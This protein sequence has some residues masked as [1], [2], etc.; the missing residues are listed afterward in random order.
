MRKSL[1][2]LPALALS[3]MLV[4]T[5]LA[6]S[7]QP[8]GGQLTGTLPPRPTVAPPATPTAQPAAEPNPAIP[9]IELQSNRNQAAPG[10]LVTLTLIVSNP[11]ERSARGVE[12]RLPLN[13]ALEVVSMVADTPGALWLNP[14]NNTYKLAIG[15]LAA[16][17]TVRLQAVLR[18][19]AD[20]AV[21]GKL[22]GWGVVAFKSGPDASATR[23]SDYVTIQVT[24]P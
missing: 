12:A 24:G 8:S 5:N 19:K 16:G 23:T 2:I 20:A 1:T 11:N 17:S 18:V 7:F 13:P 10:N 22:Y 14:Q 3:A 9:E 21:D 4:F 6:A 15:N